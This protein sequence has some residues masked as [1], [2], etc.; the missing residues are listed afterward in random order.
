MST[1]DSPAFRNRISLIIIKRHH[2]AS[3]CSVLLEEFP[4][5]FWF[6]TAPI[7]SGESVTDVARN[8]QTTLIKSDEFVNEL[9]MIFSL[10]CYAK[11]GVEYHH[12]GFLCYTNDENLKNSPSFKWSD[13]D[14][15]SVLLNRGNLLDSLPYHICVA[16]NAF[17]KELWASQMV[18]AEIRH[19]EVALEEGVIRSS[20]EGLSPGEVVVLEFMQVIYRSSSHH[21]HHCRQLRP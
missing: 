13:A 10:I 11:A 6:P 9:K 12:Y 20:S 21:P 1:T 7:I 16:Q 4:N 17:Q 18:F 5:G 3:K 14:W 2:V 19:K 15:L 8:L